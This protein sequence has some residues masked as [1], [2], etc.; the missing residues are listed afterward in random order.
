M[1]TTCCSQ[2]NQLR[3]PKVQGFGAI[4]SVLG[5]S[6]VRLVLL[7]VGSVEGQLAG[8]TLFSDLRVDVLRAECLG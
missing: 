7:H 5:L 4:H 8:M 6:L 1:T 2:A 3:K